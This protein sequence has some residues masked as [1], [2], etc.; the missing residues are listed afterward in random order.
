[1]HRRAYFAAALTA[2]LLV[3]G[4][5]AFAADKP[6]AAPRPAGRAAPAMALSQM[7][8]PEAVGFDGARLQRLDDYMA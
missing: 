5:H 2:A 1:M 3:S 7:T 6:A 4:V 8:S